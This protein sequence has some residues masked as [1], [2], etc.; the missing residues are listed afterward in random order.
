MYD[1]TD[2]DDRE[3]IL[4]RRAGKYKQIRKTDYHARD[5]VRH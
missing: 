2:D 1:I 4:E 5:R 3:R